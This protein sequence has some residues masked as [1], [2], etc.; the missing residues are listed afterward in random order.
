MITINYRSDGKQMMQAAI[1]YIQYHL[2]SFHWQVAT[3]ITALATIA[4]IPFYWQSQS[5]DAY[6]VLIHLGV[7]IFVFGRYRIYHSLIK[8][9]MKRHPIHDKEIQVTFTDEGMQYKSNSDALADD[10]A[11]WAEIPMILETSNGYIIIAPCGRF[12]WLPLAAFDTLHT[13]KAV[14]ELFAE[15]H[16][17][18]EN[19]PEWS[20]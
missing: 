18:V 6:W 13:L 17:R 5:L 11:R 20:C 10:E 12:V 7:V 2:S 3:W 9:N 14:R 16:V 15:K 1:L 8:K 4:L 19:H